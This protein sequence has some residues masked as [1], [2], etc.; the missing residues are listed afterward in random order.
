M[1]FGIPRV[2][3]VKW[4][5]ISMNLICNTH[6]THILLIQYVIWDLKKT[7]G[8]RNLRKDVKNNTGKSKVEGRRKKKSLIS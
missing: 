6:T 1:S 2:F 5:S 8:I 7:A 4:H 3:L